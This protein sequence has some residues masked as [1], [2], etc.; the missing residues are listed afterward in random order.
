MGLHRRFR[1]DTEGETIRAPQT[2][3]W[4]L[5]QWAGAD[6][7]T[8]SGRLLGQLQPVDGEAVDATT[9]AAPFSF[10]VHITVRFTHVGRLDLVTTVAL[11]AELQ[12][13]VQVTP[14]GRLLSG[15][16]QYQGDPRDRR[17]GGRKPPPHPRAGETLGD[18]T[19]SRRDGG[20]GMNTRDFRTGTVGWRAGW[21]RD[22]GH[23]YSIGRTPCWEAGRVRTPGDME[24]ILETPVSPH[25]CL[26]CVSSTSILTLTVTHNTRLYIHR[27]T[28]TLSVMYTH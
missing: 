19:V 1:A 5:Q 17:L 4:T 16:Q 24:N 3:Q 14:G 6:S 8:P 25:H 12:P 28:F 15:R 27:Y 26:M 7:R 10:A 23:A 9:H 21:G 18:W 11:S 20:Q 2:G 22:G 13:S